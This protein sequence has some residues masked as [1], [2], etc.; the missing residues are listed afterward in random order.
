MNVLIIEDEK[1]LAHELE[2][3]LTKHNYICEISY[4][5]ASASEKIAVNLYDFILL[6]LG[7]PDY[8]GLDLLK[9]ARGTNPD[10]ACIILTARAEVS[11]RIKGLDLG[12]DDYL[13]KPFSLLELQSRMQAIIRRKF[14]VPQN[15][16]DLDGFMV[17]LTDRTISYQEAQVSAITKKEFDLLAYLLLHKNRTLT[18]A[19]LG[20]HIWGSVINDDY[21]SNFID[22]HIKNIRKKLNALAP[23]DW[24]ET[25]R[26]LG[27]RIKT[28][29]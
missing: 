25:V 4:D 26:G 29:A 21:D 6:D 24:L 27:Y 3:F 7:L 28:N 1:A 9:E 8:D 5:G 15:I 17:N 16:I 14:G 12:A 23:A 22:A 13:P 19:Q 18:R 10:A 20:E 11:D 2:L